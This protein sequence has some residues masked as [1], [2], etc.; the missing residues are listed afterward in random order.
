[1]PENLR[2]IQSSVVYKPFGTGLRACIGR[3][4]AYHETILA[5]A[6]LLHRFD[7]EA[8][9]AY[10]LQVQEQITLKPEGLRLR[11]RRQNERLGLLATNTAT[12]P[13]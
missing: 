13:T 3:Q 11:P 8:D 2:P 9:P 5:L 6:F 7:F 4:F 10:Q 1:M 12:M